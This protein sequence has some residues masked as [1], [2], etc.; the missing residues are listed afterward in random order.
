VATGVA[1]D[2]AG[3]RSNAAS[4][5]VTTPDLVAPSAPTHLRGT[6]ASRPI[7][8]ALAWTASTD[9][10]GV[11]GYRIYRNNVVVATVGGTS[12]TDLAVTPNTRYAYAVTAR[13]A[14]GNE[15]PRSASVNETTPKH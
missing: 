5:M 15:S 12:W 7:R 11:T 3:N 4:V 1:I 10:V 14:A 8:V 2:A 13:D 9:D 6:T